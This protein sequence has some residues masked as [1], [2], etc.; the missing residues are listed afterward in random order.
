MLDTDFSFISPDVEL[1]KVKPLNLK[2]TVAFANFYLSQVA[3]MLNN[4]AAIAEKKIM[5]IE[6]RLE[7]ME[8]ELA[9]CE[10]K[11]K[12]VPEVSEA[13]SH[14]RNCTAVASP[15]NQSEVSISDDSELNAAKSETREIS[16]PT[17]HDTPYDEPSEESAKVLKNSEHPAYAKY[18]KM[19]KMGVVEA[20]VKQK[21]IVDGLDPLILDNPDD[22]FNGV[23]VDNSSEDEL[24]Q[25]SDS[26]YSS[27]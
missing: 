27:D 4:F 18:F 2:R 1:S 3:S 14:F 5:D 19:L 22:A 11:I 23:I 9:I 16:N 10:E 25:S 26:S 6:W 7:L 21:M 13:L 24:D 20:A 8:S 12:S 17:V 15:F